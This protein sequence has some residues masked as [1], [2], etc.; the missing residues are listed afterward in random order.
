MQFD[1]PAGTETRAQIRREDLALGKILLDNKVVTKEVVHE[2]LLLQKKVREGA[3][4]NL[5]LGE[6]LISRGHLDEETLEGILKVQA[7]KME[8]MSERLAW[9]EKSKRG[10]PAPEEQGA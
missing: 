8:L 9:R 5:L 6:L 3:G 2:C 10:G 4:M 1:N 7:A